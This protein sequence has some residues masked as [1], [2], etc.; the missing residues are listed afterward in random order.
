[1][2]TNRSPR[3]DCLIPTPGGP[4]DAPPAPP[5]PGGGGRQKVARRASFPLFP[6]IH[7]TAC[8]TRKSEGRNAA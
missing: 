5:R 6:S 8:T 7:R 1:M 3:L 2:T 4:Q